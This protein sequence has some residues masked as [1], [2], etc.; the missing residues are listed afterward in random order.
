MKKGY[1]IFEIVLVLR[2][3]AR[4]GSLLGG[5]SNIYEQRSF[6]YLRENIIYTI[7]SVKNANLIWYNYNQLASSVNSNWTLGLNN[8][9]SRTINSSQPYY[10]GVI[11]IADNSENTNDNYY[12][13]QYSQEKQ[14]WQNWDKDLFIAAPK[15]SS[16][17]IKA[18]NWNWYSSS[19]AYGNWKKIYLNKI[20]DYNPNNPWLSNCKTI[21]N[22]YSAILLRFDPTELEPIFCSIQKGCYNYL[23]AP[24]NWIEDYSNPIIASK[25][26]KL[27][28]STISDWIWEV[29]KYPDWEII[30]D[31]KDFYLLNE[32]KTI[33]N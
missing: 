25:K 8:N 5:L 6:S 7:Q 31:T 10:H 19:K 2:I 23:T 33:L 3:F 4:M 27:C 15:L 26:M 21:P 24:P 12:I 32:Y 9:L 13:V 22:E 1:S 14:L 17:I 11:F 18:P 28:F 30:I 20:I 29:W 16:Q